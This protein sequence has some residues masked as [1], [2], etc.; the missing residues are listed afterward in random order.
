MLLQEYEM[1]YYEQSVCSSRSDY[2][3]DLMHKAPS[4]QGT[5]GRFVIYI[6]ET[7]VIVA[8]LSWPPCVVAPLMLCKQ[9]HNSELA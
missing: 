4:S 7:D 8:T 3:Y 5:M 9:D 1:L 6:S 2:D